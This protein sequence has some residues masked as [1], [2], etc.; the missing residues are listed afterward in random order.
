MTKYIVLLIGCIECGVPSYPVAITETKEQA[1][2]IVNQQKSTWE[3]YGGDGFY[4]I[5]EVSH[6]PKGNELLTNSS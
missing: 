3:L 5:W 4:D 2:I 6:I 1:E